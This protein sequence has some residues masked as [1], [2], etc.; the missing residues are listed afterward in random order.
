[1]HTSTSHFA[2]VELRSPPLHIMIPTQVHGHG[3]DH[4]GVVLVGSQA[5]KLHT[6]QPPGVCERAHSKSHIDKGL[7]RIV[8]KIRGGIQTTRHPSPYCSL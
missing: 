1:M 5:E 7:V 3:Y 2:N 4:S 8:Q 6:G